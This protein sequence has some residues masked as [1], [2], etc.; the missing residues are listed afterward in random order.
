MAADDEK[1]QAPT[2]KKRSQARDEGQIL[3]SQDF[4]SFVTLAAGSAAMVGCFSMISTRFTAFTVGLLGELDRPIDG[5]LGAEFLGTWTISLGPIMAAVVAAGIAVG[6]LQ[7]GVYFNV[8]KIVT[9]NFQFLNILEGLKKILLSV[10]SLVQILFST[11]KIVVLGMI[12]FYTLIDWVFSFLSHDPHTFAGIFASAGSVSVLLLIRLAI[13]MA[14][15]ALMDWCIKRYQHEEKLKMSVQDIKDETKQTEGSP[16]IK[17]ARKRKQYELAQQ[18][19]IQNVAEA[20]VVV[21][22]PTHYAVALAYKSEKMDS[23]RVVAKGTDELA[24]RIRSAAR[25]AS[26]PILPRPPLARAL[27]RRVK[28]G[29][30]I[31][32]DLFQAVAVVL[33]YVYRLRNK[34]G[35]A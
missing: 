7:V 4:S 8:E 20:D 2:G 32:E 6:L 34:R 13:A 31:P 35:A 19:S 23:P 25:R 22:N 15:I 26:V 29:Q 11:F 5:T 9:P 27:Y 16:E 12:C 28:V 21:V 14:V 30:A 17:G 10:E 18:R 24:E 1:D 3:Q 33:A